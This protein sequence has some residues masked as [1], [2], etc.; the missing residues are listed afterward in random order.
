MNRRTFVHTAG[1]AGSGICFSSARQASPSITPVSVGII[2]LDT[3]HAPAFTKIINATGSN[4]H[5]TG[6]KVTHAY[7]QG[8]R[9]IES[10]A[11]RIPGYTKELT[12]L[13]VE[14]VSSIESLL[15]KVDVVLLETNDGRLHKEQAQLAI[16]AQKPLFIDKPMA[17]N[18]KDVVTIFN[19]AHKHNVPLFSSS[20]LR[21]SPSIQAVKQGKIGSVLGA[22]TWSPATIEKTHPDLFW[23]GI[24]GVESLFALMGTGCKTVQRTYSAGAD[25]VVGEWEDGRIGVFRGLRDGKTGY[26][27]MAFGT[28]GMVEAGL[29]Q[30]YEHLVAEIIQF[31]KTGIPPVKAAETIEI[32]AFME[33]AELSKKRAGKRVGLREVMKRVEGGG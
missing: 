13:E 26:G 15:K 32:F 3:S 31:F 28:E 4:S 20:S 11:S 25:V 24:H 33:A 8:S 2:G 23:Y 18:L 16:E 27:G 10:S 21:F 7:P 9:D 14:I 29:Y 30:G 22:N 12:A 1:L 19:L 6:F 17:A 5:P